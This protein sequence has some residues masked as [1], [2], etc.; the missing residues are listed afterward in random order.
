M[1]IEGTLGKKKVGIH[2]IHM[3]EDAGK[4]IHNEWDDCSLTDY[5]RNSMLLIEI[6]SE[7]NMRSTDEMIAYLGRLRLIIQYLGISNCK[8]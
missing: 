5:N 3:K 2:E 4:P 7:P 1:E 6:M 8:L